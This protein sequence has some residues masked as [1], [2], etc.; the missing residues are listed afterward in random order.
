MGSNYTYNIN[1]IHDIQKK[2]IEM[3][4]FTKYTDF[5][6]KNLSIDHKLL[7]IYDFCKYKTLILIHIYSIE[8]IIKLVFHV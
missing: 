8:Y 6:L 4:F 2:S 1:C 3:S 7:N 5:S